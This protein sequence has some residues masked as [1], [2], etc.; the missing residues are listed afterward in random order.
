MIE[1]IKENNYLLNANI[2]NF[3]LNHILDD[4][5]EFSFT[6]IFRKIIDKYELN[7]NDK[8]GSFCLGFNF[9]HPHTFVSK[10]INLE[11]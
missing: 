8:F 5:I 3:I 4:H 2:Q 11:Y 6:F 7:L 9:E 10:M 1:S